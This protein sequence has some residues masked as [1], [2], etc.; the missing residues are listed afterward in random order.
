MKH[1]SAS[2]LKMCGLCGEDCLIYTV[3]D[4]MPVCKDCKPLPKKKIPNEAS[5]LKSLLKAK[6]KESQGI[7]TMIE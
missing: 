6:E 3:I 4:N 1:K 5:M 2:R 7:L